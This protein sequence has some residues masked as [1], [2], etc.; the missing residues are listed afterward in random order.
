M[1]TM[2]NVQRYDAGEDAELFSSVEDACQTMALVEACF[3]SM[4]NPAEPLDLG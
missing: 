4:K 2:R 3:A 1:G